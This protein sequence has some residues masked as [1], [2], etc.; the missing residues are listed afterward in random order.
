M[1]PLLLDGPDATVLMLEDEVVQA[2]A[3]TTHE[4]ALALNLDPEV[5]RQERDRMRRIQA[6][7]RN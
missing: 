2:M 5:Y 4:K 1:A 7:E 6:S 3:K